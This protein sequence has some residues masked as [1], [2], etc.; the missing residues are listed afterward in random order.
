MNMKDQM[1]EE[2][3]LL[4]RLLQDEGIFSERADNVIAR[5]NSNPARISFEQRRL[6]FLHELV[7]HSAAYNISSSFHL[8][9]PLN[10]RAL[11]F[12]LEQI[13]ERHEI[14]RAAFREVDGEPWQF[15]E[16]KIAL[17]FQFLDWRT[18]A[19]ADIEAELAA[20]AR[21]EAHHSFDLKQTPLFRVTLVQYGELSH[22]LFLTLHHIIADA[23]SI[24]IFVQEFM[25]LYHACSAGEPNPLQPL[26]VQY[27]DYAAWQL[28]NATEENLG[29]QLAYWEERLA[30]L[31]LLDF[32]TDFPRPK[33]QTFNG[34][35]V[36]FRVP[37]HLSAALVKLSQRQRKTLFTTL[38]AA[39]QVLL[40]RYAHQQ[41]I[42]VGTSFANRANE[43]TQRLIGFFVNMLVLRTDLSGAQTFL[44]L[45]E[46]VGERILEAFENNSLPYERLVEQ[47][48]PRRDTSRNPL[49]QIAFTLLNTPSPEL[50]LDDLLI[51]PLAN[52]DAAR[53][54][55]EFFMR[56]EAAGLSGTIS[57]NTDLFLPQTMERLAVSF[58][59]LL[60]N[61]ARDPGQKIS[62][63]SLLS[64][65][66]LDELA[67]SEARAAFPVV[68]CLHETF[69]KQADLWPERIALKYDGAEMSYGEL[70]RR[71]N[72]VA[73]QLIER[74]VGP[75][76]MVGLLADR[77]FEM[78]VGIL[79]ILKAGGAYVPLDPAY[80]RE[81]FTYMIEDCRVA[82]VLAARGLEHRLGECAVEILIL[83][84]MLARIERVDCSNPA[85]AVAPENLAYVIYTSG[86][87]GRPKGVLVTHANVQR[88]MLSTAKWFRFDERDVWTLFHSFAFDFSVWE[89]WGALLYGGRLIIVPKMTTR[90]LEDFYNL[91]CDEKVTV[92]NQTPSAFRQLIE[93]E[94]ELGREAE[95][96]LRYVIFGGEAL[97]LASLEPWI[98]RHGD[99][100]PALINMYGIT[101]TTVHVTFRRI[102]LRDV[103]SRSGSL[104]GVP[105]PD[106]EVYLLDQHLNPVPTGATGEIFVGG[107]GLSRGYFNRP[108]LTAQRFVAN[109]FGREGERL[110]RSG[111]LA[112]ALSEGE[113]EYRGR[114]DN[115]LKV[116]GY[117]IEPAEIETVL[118]EHGAVQQVVVVPRE[119]NSRDRL[120][121][122]VVPRLANDFTELAANWQQDQVYYWNSTFD[123]IYGDA[124]AG[125]DETFNL[126]GWT[127]SYDDSPIPAEEMR[128]WLEETISAIGESRPKKILE[129]GCGTGMLLFRLAPQA[130]AYVATDFSQIALSRLDNLVSA[131][132]LSHVRLLHRRAEDFADIPTAFFDAVI[133]NSTIQYFPSVSY[134]LKVLEGAINAV[135]PSGLIFIGDVRSLPLLRAYHAGVRM[136]RA[137]EETT[138]SEFKAELDGALD[139]EEELV[140]DE[141]FFLKLQQHFPQIG[142]VQVRLKTV[143]DRNELTKFRYNVLLYLGER[144]PAA[145]PAVTWEDWLP[146]VH[147]PEGLRELLKTRRE[148]AWG[149]RNIPNL[150]LQQERQLFDWLD[151]LEGPETLGAF[152]KSRP[153]AAPEDGCDPATIY[154]LAAE[155]HRKCLLS[156]SGDSMLGEFDAC[157]WE[158]PPEQLVPDRRLDSR[159]LLAKEWEQF[160]NQPFKGKYYARLAPLLKEYAAKRLPDYMIPSEIMLIKQLPL[161]P[162]GKLDRRS[163]PLPKSA[164]EKDGRILT[165]P[166]TE[167]ERRLARIWG[168]VLGIERVRLEDNFFQL[169]GHSL[170]A[171]QLISRVRSEFSIELPLRVLF[172]YPALSAFCGRVEI[173]LHAGGKRRSPVAR[174]PHQSSM[175]LSFAQQRL[176]FHDQLEGP[177]ATYNIAAAIDLVGEL[178]VS[179]LERS[180]T[181]IVR[182]HQILRTI[183][184]REN[185]EPVQ[186]VLPAQPFSI[187]MRDISSAP[188]GEQASELGQLLSRAAAIA[189]DLRNGPVLRALLVRL[190]DQRHTLLVAIHH[191]ACD[192][193]SM[194]V[195]TREL[196]AF[197]DGFSSGALQS[198]EDLPIQHVDF[199]W[200]QRQWLT[201]I[202]ARRQLDFWRKELAGAPP[203][204][205]LP[206][207]RPR[208][209]A[210]T[211]RGQHLPLQLDPNLLSQLQALAEQTGTTIYVLLLTVIVAMLSHN[212][213]QSEVVIGSPVANRDDE[214]LESLI[215]FF[216]NTLALRI[217][218]AGD[219]EMLELLNRVKTTVLDAFSNQDVP[220]DLVVEHLNPVRSL[221]HAPLF[222]VMFVFQNFPGQ[223][224]SL[225]SLRVES[226]PIQTEVSKFDLTFLVEQSDEGL[227]GVI[228]YNTDLFDPG[229][230]ER[231]SRHL[232]TAL[233][234]LVNNPQQRLSQLPMLTADEREQ[235]L[236]RWNDTERAYPTGMCIHQ[237]FEAEVEKSPEAVAVLFEGERL[238][239]R[240]LNEKAN[241]LAHY[242]KRSGVG[243]EVLVGLCVERSVEMIVGLLG[244]LKA[245]GAYV[246]LEPSVP[247]ERL[248]FMLEDARVALLL[249]Q[250]KLVESLPEARPQTVCLDT[251]WQSIALHQASNPAVEAAAAASPAYVIYTSGST[252]R[253]KGVIVEHRNLVNSTLARL[254]YYSEPVN[255]FLLLSS[256]AFDSSVA[257]IFWTLCQGGSLLMVPE[258]LQREVTQ[259]AE[260]IDRQ[261]VSHL[262]CLPSLYEF[263]LKQVSAASCRT[264]KSVIVAGEACPAILVAEHFGLLPETALYNEYGPTEASVW[265][266]AY[267]ARPHEQHASV[268]IGRP[269]AN[270]RAYILNRRLNPTP[271]GVPGELFIGGAGI[272]R[273][274]LNSAQLTAEK[275]IPDPFSAEAGARLYRTGDL[276]RF[277]RDGN[278]EF[279]G[280]AD[281][282]VKI[283]GFRVELAEVEA[284]LNEHPGVRQVV[285]MSREDAPGNRRLAAYVIAQEGAVPTAS[286]LRRYL[287]ERM[288]EYM[289]PSTFT[290]LDTLPQ[291]P[292]GKVNRR[293]LLSLSERRT[294]DDSDFV[295][296]RTPV[297]K[298]LSRIWA[299]TLGLEKVG[300]RDDFFGLG[301]HSLL[302]LKLM[303]EIEQTFKVTLPLAVLF[304][305]ST[306]ADLAAE[307]ELSSHESNTS[308]L[309]RI[310]E[311]GSFP[312]IF[313]A[314]DV[315]GQVLSYYPLAAHLK[316]HHPLY[317]LQSRPVNGQ[318]TQTVAALAG[319]YLHEIRRVQ[320][321]GPYILAGH[322]SGAI[323]AFE[324]AAQLEARGE[325]VACLLVFDTVAPR[326]GKSFFELPDNEVDLLVYAVQTLAIFFEREIPLRREELEAL[327][328]EERFA[329]ALARM[330]E[331]QLLPVETSAGQMAEMFKIYQSNINCLKDYEPGTIHAPVYLW[332]AKESPL[333]ETEPPG[334]G[335]AELTTAEVTVFEAD[336]NHV[337]MM[338]EPGVSRIAAQLQSVTGRFKMAEV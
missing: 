65:S 161:T 235:V 87:T 102:E 138:R 325:R 205:N 198:L 249:T 167:L 172:E 319:D 217:D 90:S 204:L 187:E 77:S 257:G 173:L 223:E 62:E 199:A 84:D 241:R 81:R 150:R 296:P 335:W 106:L 49:F 216:V 51:R 228:E 224:L 283:R 44:E 302:A 64:A 273:G 166:Q 278:I 251:D 9:G 253:P 136:A 226:R 78:L 184:L 209:P 21:Q 314:H 290:F 39:F 72:C 88:L 125:I 134:L 35:L 58:I 157:F 132:G 323:V 238:S 162:S 303:S 23:W 287:S 121:A 177:S 10:R 36:S 17:P 163:L 206:T 12:A 309:V 146:G 225:R 174:A 28:E 194:G 308:P 192:G 149:I 104:I 107:A 220:F 96:A 240:E 196:A 42:A 103:K 266:T 304:R 208:P 181:E 252:G 120:V 99:E 139:R 24:G 291:L 324:M 310:Q 69:E 4:N 153:P 315:S 239:Y 170:L 288:P 193:W 140:I 328:A 188:P 142:G 131:R 243:P 29:K 337:S 305:A 152:L 124:Q 237:L 262:L 52:Q 110:Y 236:V 164:N 284:V 169:G 219:P 8:D 320:P 276:A 18:H 155:A 22:A 16:E 160:A 256:F 279:L 185:G 248:S 321:R 316:E 94:K 258:G 330:Q 93:V 222:Q 89:I 182:R 281:D 130:A 201:T 301:G 272:A 122:Y 34:G 311:Q 186:R 215:G 179:A 154:R 189:F 336:G 127:S 71:A 86:S 232:N 112:R 264:L 306:I 233:L 114:A 292:N 59:N 286:Q 299:E 43:D 297:E 118:G 202:E 47:I 293:A 269:I 307:L 54:D 298:E 76:V 327:D 227:S 75:E 80:P 254:S 5:R 280:R 317:A 25:A 171:T 55:F 200:W 190:S 331:Y 175:P 218:A 116:R 159:P 95:I 158:S 31:P 30:E 230:I 70:N 242:L 145:S 285:L 268:P 117:R 53:F 313:F 128:A 126:S 50:A 259:L 56:E 101:E 63:L 82:M 11:V 210:Q 38:M 32:P 20:L 183:Y 57:Y 270:V 141:Q 329:L 165:R 326:A 247:Q 2:L 143:D 255:C 100:Y 26:R 275:F 74:G 176:W 73:R 333:A 1:N 246:P 61:I 133:I 318:G 260:L 67:G 115:Q 294:G 211:F 261:Q 60:E 113:L 46:Q 123:E 137:T 33:L 45:L 13:T 250:A 213:G 135:G 27:S 14:L 6:W 148:K 168:E 48:D 144:A 68:Q 111:D 322:S 265:S 83:D 180:L 91:L 214:E 119:I 207:D 97:D 108:E 312:A 156:W 66:E 98:D 334:R 263:L 191:I 229:T 41:D 295:P 195:L 3:E 40:A 151:S 147:S 245:G 267:R 197:Y 221:S 300:I 79:A 109:P 244:I 178:Q 271:I 231:M 203:V 282:Q 274:Y 15:V 289:V 338:K 105:L 19:E 85:T 129:I 234:C 92:L 7:P 212:S 277:V 37:A 332:S